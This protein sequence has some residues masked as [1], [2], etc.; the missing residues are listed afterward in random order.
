MR[1]GV[2][3]TLVG[4]AVPVFFLGYLLKQVFAVDLGWFPPS[5]RQAVGR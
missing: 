2:S 5:G 4:V 3:A 1:R